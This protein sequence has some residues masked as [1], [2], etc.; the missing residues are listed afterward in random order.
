[1]NSLKLAS[2]KFGRAFGYGFT[3]DNKVAAVFVNGQYNRIVQGYYRINPI[4]EEVLPPISTGMRV[5]DYHV[6]LLTKDNFEVKWHIKVQFF[7]DLRK[8]VNPSVACTFIEN[9]LIGIVSTRLQQI[10]SLYVAKYNL[11]EL[12]AESV[13]MVLAASAHQFI[14]KKAEG[15]G[16]SIPEDGVIFCEIDLP[17]SYHE[18]VEEEHRMDHLKEILAADG[19]LSTQ[20][21]LIIAFS[22]NKGTGGEGN[23]NGIMPTFLMLQN[24]MN[25]NPP[26]PADP[27][28]TP[29]KSEP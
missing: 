16:I 29:P 13:R 11:A 15:A 9:T 3:G 22:S 7:F 18:I 5:G 1:M 8:A 26:R 25:Q 24:L 21:K 28:P 10:L 17:D 2:W 14:N 6:P 4:Y 20:D 19:E 23:I 12:N 27:P